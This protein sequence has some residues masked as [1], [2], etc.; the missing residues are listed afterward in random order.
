MEHSYK[1]QQHSIHTHL[2]VCSVQSMTL[3]EADNPQRKN[4]QNI[5]YLKDVIFI[6]HFDISFSCYI[7]SIYSDYSELDHL[8]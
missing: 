7:F 5:H 2:Y 4:A 1:G 8:K 3:N 6:K